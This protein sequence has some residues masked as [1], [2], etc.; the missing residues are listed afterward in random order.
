[1]S[2]RVQFVRIGDNRSNLVS[3]TSGVPQGSIIGPFIF[4]MVAGSF[5]TDVENAIVIKYADDFTVCA[6]MLKGNSNNHLSLLHESFLKWSIDHGLT[7]NKS[8]CKSLCVR[9]KNPC[10]PV[11]LPHVSFVKDLK[12]L[13]VTFDERL[14]WNTH[15]DLVVKNASKQLYV[16]RVLKNVVS[17][18]QLVTVFNAIVRSR[19]EYASPLLVGLSSENSK[20]L[21]RVQRRFHR[22]LCAGKECQEECLP[23]LTTRRLAAAMKLFRQ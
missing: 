21:E 3:V 16:L 8:K 7:V 22:L 12:I 10:S 20:K 13:G 6:A 5:S 19:L 4:S 17:H 2:N 11:I 15:C 18:D 14:N 23:S 1:M 9:F